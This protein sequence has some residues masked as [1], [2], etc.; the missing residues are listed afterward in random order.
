M[1]RS[2]WNAENTKSII[3]K[4]YDIS[5]VYGLPNDKQ[6]VIFA[7][8]A[9]SCEL[10]LKSLLYANKDQ[11]SIVKGHDISTLFE[12][13]PVPIKTKIEELVGENDFAKKLEANKDVFMIFRYS[14]EMKGYKINASFL[15]KLMK[16]LSELCKGIYPKELTDG[17]G[18]LFRC[19]Y[20]A[21]GVLY[22]IEAE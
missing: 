6:E 1:E 8:V 21:N 22:K 9:L 3:E 7:L 15:L 10:Y 17:K 19:G 18:E 2:Y 4:S 16:A 14:Y 20:A 11:Q 13:L 12:K 5:R